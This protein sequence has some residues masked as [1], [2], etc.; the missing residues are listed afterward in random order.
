[1]C[2]PSLVVCLLV[3]LGVEIALPQAS[4]EKNPPFKSSDYPRS[5]FLVTQSTHEI[6]NVKV[7]IIHAKRRKQSE[8]PPSFCRAWVE[9]REGA[10]LIRR[11][12]YGDFEPVGYSYGVFVPAKQPSSD[13]FVFVKE[14]DYDGHLGLVDASGHLTDTLGGT[15]FVAE[16][17]FLVSQYSSDE[18]GLAVFDF[19]A[20]KLTLKTNDITYPYQ[21]YRDAA[22][23]FFTESEWSDN[24][25]QAHEKP[26]VA[27][28]LDLR[29]GGIVKVEMSASKL[30]SAAA[31]KDD[32][33]PRKSEDCTSR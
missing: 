24:S 3:L 11:I 19:K 27:Y 4:V 23:Y 1:M 25:G 20:H 21:W 16:G 10:T 18:A 8:T 12:Y 30:H 15:F 33:D 6:G 2:R 26:G 32:F 9:I 13:Y 14:G 7:R 22:G 17:R 29:R 5:E 31:V 28:R